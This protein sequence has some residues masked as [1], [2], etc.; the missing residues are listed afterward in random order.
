[1]KRYIAF[2]LVITLWTGSVWAQPIA[3][4]VY[5]WANAPVTKKPTS[6]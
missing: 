5:K 1:M 3:S 2:S 6:E 4:D